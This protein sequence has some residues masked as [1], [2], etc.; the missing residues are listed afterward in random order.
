MRITLLITILSICSF[1]AYSQE[2]MEP[3]IVYEG[4]G[5]MLLEDGA[6]VDGRFRFYPNSPRKVFF[7]EEG[8]EK[9]EKMKIGEIVSFK[10][11]ADE[12]AKVI[13]KGAVGSSDYF[14]KR[15][16]APENDIQVYLYEQQNSIGN[17]QGFLVTREYHVQKSDWDQSYSVAN[18]KFM[19]FHKKG[20]AMVEDCSDLA[21]KI[22]KKEKGYKMGMVMTPSMKADVYLR[23]SD[24]YQSCK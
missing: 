13:N 11:G 24:E 16:T 7:L 18:L 20:S 9:R 23:I 17:E 6:T 14:M 10:I 8:A 19:P 2:T 15:L 3:T 12:W 1:F 21:K 5:S 22:S 4:D